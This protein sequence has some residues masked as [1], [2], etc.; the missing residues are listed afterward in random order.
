LAEFI[1][2]LRDD[3]SDRRIQR[4]KPAIG[5]LKPSIDFFRFNLAAD[6]RWVRPPPIDH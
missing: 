5:R 6:C 1:H 2:V 3:H 4:L